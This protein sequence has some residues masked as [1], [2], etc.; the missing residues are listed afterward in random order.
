ME[1]MYDLLLNLLAPNLTEWLLPTGKGNGW[2]L[3][4]SVSVTCVNRT[5]I[6]VVSDSRAYWV[7]GTKQ[8]SV[9]FEEAPPSSACPLMCARCSNCV[10]QHKL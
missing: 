5:E 6:L 3:H 7:Q 9:P 4:S 8:Q 1:K 10:T 2:K